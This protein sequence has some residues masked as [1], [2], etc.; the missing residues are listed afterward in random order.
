VVC[1]GIDHERDIAQ[2]IRVLA[3]L[4]VRESE[5]DDVVPGQ[6]LGGGVLQGEVRERAQVRL[7][8]DQRLARVGMRGHGADLDVRVASEQ[9]ED[10]ASRIAGC[11]GDGDGIRHGSTLTVWTLGP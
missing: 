7:M 4:A 11:A 1:A 8:L 3:G 10:L 6:D 5:E 9:A 2:S